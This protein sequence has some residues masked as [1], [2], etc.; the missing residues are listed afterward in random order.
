MTLE[1]QQK[2]RRNEIAI[3]NDTLR[4]VQEGYV[5]PDMSRGSTNTTGIVRDAK[6]ARPLINALLTKL[7]ELHDVEAEVAVEKSKENGTGNYRGHS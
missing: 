3:I 1:D 4:V 2:E 7:A 6:F 5:K